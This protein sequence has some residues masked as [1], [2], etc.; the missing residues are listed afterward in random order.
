MEL[1]VPEPGL[2]ISYAYLWRHEHESGLEEGRKDRPC[3]I[4]LQIERKGQY[5]LVT[6]A[7]VTHRE[8]ELPSVGVEIPPRVKTHL[9]LD[10]ERSWVIL[11]EVNQFTWPGY[12]LR[13]TSKGGRIDYGFLPPNLFEKIKSE[14]LRLIMERRADITLRDSDT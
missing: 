8:P 4:V 5:P 12:D 3:V 9:G 2:V 1:P 10:H 11:S 7:P 14:M 13:A 6:V